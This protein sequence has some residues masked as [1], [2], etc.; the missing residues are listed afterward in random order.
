[1]SWNEMNKEILKLCEEP[2]L[3]NCF[4]L[5]G[6]SRVT[7]FYDH[8]SDHEF[9]I[10]LNK[11]LTSTTRSKL[12]KKYGYQVVRLGEID[13]RRPDFGFADKLVKNKEVVDLIWLNQELVERRTETLGL[14]GEDFWAELSLWANLNRGIWLTKNKIIISN[15]KSR[16]I[17][18][19][20]LKKLQRKSIGLETLNNLIKLKV[21]GSWPSLMLQ[22]SILF[23]DEALRNCLEARVYPMGEK[24]LLHE[25]AK[26]KP[27][28]AKLWSEIFENPKQA[29]LS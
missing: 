3:K 9:S 29:K 25:F 2:I 11:T 16:E 10:W 4:I 26:I 18:N 6:G 15:K 12:Y 13:P 14:A 7:D 1:M 20:F 17:D 23:E 24:W 21:R 8:M 28:R 22:L 5:Q 19:H 27:K